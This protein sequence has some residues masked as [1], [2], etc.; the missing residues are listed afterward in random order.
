MWIWTDLIMA[1]FLFDDTCRTYSTHMQFST[2]LL[3]SWPLFTLAPLFVPSQFSAPPPHSLS[4]SIIELFPSLAF[5]LSLFLH[6]H[7]LRFCIIV[8]T[9]PQHRGTAAEATSDIY[10]YTSV[11]W[12]SEM[13][14]FRYT[15]R[16]WM[17]GWHSE[18]PV[19]RWFI[20]HSQSEVVVITFDI[21]RVKT[22]LRTSS[23]CNTR[24][25]WKCFILNQCEWISSFQTFKQRQTF[26]FPSQLLRIIFFI[27]LQ[28]HSPL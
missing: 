23:S 20:N 7:G 2:G 13:R 10:T 17:S 3:L 1:H 5:P 24:N 19:L 16:F 27:C 21:Q 9:R 12:D 26:V 11:M 25:N 15:R 22:R 28:H 14:F 18:F 8:Y 6:V 4:L